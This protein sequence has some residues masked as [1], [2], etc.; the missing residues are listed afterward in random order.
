MKYFSWFLL[1][2]L[3]GA[4]LQSCNDLPSSPG[5]SFITDT[6]ITTVLSSSD[7]T[8]ITGGF[9]GLVQVP[10][11]NGGDQA[12]TNI[13]LLGQTPSARAM[14]FI[15]FSTVPDSVSTLQESEIISASLRL[16]PLGYTFGDTTSN[17][18]QFTVSRIT[19][20]W[21]PSATIDTIQK[22]SFIGEQFQSFSGSIALGD[23]ADPVRIM[24]PDKAA[25]YQWLFTNSAG[26]GLALVPESGST[27]VRQFSTVGIGDLERASATIELVYKRA[28]SD[29][30]DTVNVASAFVNTF[31]E[32][33]APV[34]EETLTVQ[35]SVLYRSHLF[36]DV[37]MIPSLATIHRA[38]LILTWNP[39]ASM[40]GTTGPPESLNAYFA[41]DSSLVSNDGSY[42]RATRRIDSKEY[43]F[44][45]IGTAV[46]RWLRGA[47]N[48]GLVLYMD[49]GSE[50]R[51][52][53]RLVFYGPDDPDPAKRPRL[54]IVYSAKPQKKQ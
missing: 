15:R 36:F 12:N 22:G 45:N 30:T 49:V 38:E 51:K 53:D 17:Q 44:P 11:S 23:S 27:V 6:L 41:T 37:S 7:T 33:L 5:S 40:F 16:Q 34:P 42:A 46:E 48:Y 18:L 32:S 25:L 35:G 9:S 50:L 8:L 43:L 39:E 31:V 1:A 14:S 19:S 26:Y 3:A 13:F 24:F 10:I 52:L 47:P 20:P 2:V 54:T 21:A 28:G 4:G 29:Q